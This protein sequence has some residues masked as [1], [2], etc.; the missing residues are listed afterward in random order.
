MGEIYLLKYDRVLW[1]RF[2][3]L[4]PLTTT[5]LDVNN[6]PL[7]LIPLCKL[8]DRKNSLWLDIEPSLLLMRH[9]GIW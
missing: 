3:L 7:G 8:N 1:V 6:R 4:S 2:A 5:S 9:Y